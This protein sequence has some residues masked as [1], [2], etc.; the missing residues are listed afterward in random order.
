MLIRFSIMSILLPMSPSSH[1]YSCTML[2]LSICSDTPSHAQ[3]WLV[4]LTPAGCCSVMLRCCSVVVPLFRCC[5]VVVSLLFRCCS[6]LF[7]CYTVVV[8]FLF[9]CCFVVVPLLFSVVPLLYRCCSVFVPLLFRCCF[10]VVPLLFRC[11]SVVVPFLFRCCSVVV[12]LLF[13][14]CSVVVQCRLLLVCVAQRGSVLIMLALRCSALFNAA[15]VLISST[16]FRSC[17]SCLLT[18]QVCTVRAS[19]QM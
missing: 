3:Y 6:V 8:P 16:H 5:T 18:A 15:H 17:E 11:C 12:P 10:V 14:C 4:L 2:R 7:R 19:L 1:T 13:R 9:R